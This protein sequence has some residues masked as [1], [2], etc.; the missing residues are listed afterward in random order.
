M[1]GAKLKFN[2]VANEQILPNSNG[3]SE[4]SGERSASPENHTDQSIMA[5]DIQAKD[6]GI[7]KASSGV[8]QIQTVISGFNSGRTYCVRI[9]SIQLCQEVM[10][11]LSRAAKTA[12]AAFE[13]KTAFRKSQETLRDI[14]NSRPFQFGT[15]LLIFAVRPPRPAMRTPPSPICARHHASASTAARS[16]FPTPPHYRAPRL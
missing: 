14:Y 9:P 7:V 6:Q 11:A 10:E 12:R 13:A 5:N 15:A 1:A 2:Q 8:L 4:G 3:E 16:D